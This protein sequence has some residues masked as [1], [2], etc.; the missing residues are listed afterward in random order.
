MFFTIRQMFIIALLYIW[1][2]S[3][4]I[5]VSKEIYFNIITNLKFWIK[6]TN[7]CTLKVY[8]WFYLYKS[9]S[10]KVNVYLHL[11]AQ[12]LQHVTAYW[13]WSV[14]LLVSYYKLLLTCTICDWTSPHI[15]K[16]IWSPVL[17]YSG[18]GPRQFIFVCIKSN[19]QS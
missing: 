12:R 15:W 10:H 3:G 8:E 14:S 11:F 9:W 6:K 7:V 18:D 2:E 16:L 17:Y 5:Q 19:L 13:P 4:V 1:P